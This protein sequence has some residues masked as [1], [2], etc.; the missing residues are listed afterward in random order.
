MP[1]PEMIMIT[2]SL[3]LRKYDGHYEKLLP[4][5]QDP[6]GDCFVS[7]GDVTAK[8]E[9]PPIAI[10]E[11]RYRGRGIGFLVMQTVI[12]RLKELGVPV[13][14]GSTVYKWNLPSQKMHEKLGFRRVGETEEDFIYELDLRSLRQP[15][16]CSCNSP[17]AGI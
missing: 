15:V 1:Q 9:N 16:P 17:K 12:S 2:P 4:G 11:A 7:I 3:R 5:Y 13:I 10:W 8:A 6:E 14:K